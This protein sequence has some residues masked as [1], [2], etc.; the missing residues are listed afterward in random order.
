[1]C[2]YR[3]YL[4][5][6]LACFEYNLNSKFISRLLSAFPM[7]HILSGIFTDLSMWAQHRWEI[8]CTKRHQKKEKKVGLPKN[9]PRTYFLT[10]ICTEMPVEHEYC[11]SNLALDKNWVE[12]KLASGAFAVP[13]ITFFFPLL[14]ALP[15]LS[16]QVSSLFFACFLPS[17]H[18]YSLIGIWRSHSFQSYVHCTKGPW[19]IESTP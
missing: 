17:T 7:T 4:H 2:D 12:G 18:E 9:I 11:K 6:S 16:C 13:S 3:Q 19:K 15:P 14:D 8:T 10:E 5:A 1:M